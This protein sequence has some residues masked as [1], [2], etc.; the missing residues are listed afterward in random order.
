MYEL[1]LLLALLCP[2][3]GQILVTSESEEVYYYCP[4]CG[5]TFFSNMSTEE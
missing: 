5:Y 2:I 3:C 1:L 4:E